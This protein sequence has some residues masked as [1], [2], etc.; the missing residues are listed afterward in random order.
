MIGISK[1][2]P[3]KS[4]K[5]Y[6]ELRRVLSARASGRYRRRGAQRS[7]TQSVSYRSWRKSGNLLLIPSLEYRFARVASVS[8]HRRWAAAC[9][10]LKI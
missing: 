3:K 9:R 7:N 2:N 4:K 8:W 10:R 1:K 5:S 6:V